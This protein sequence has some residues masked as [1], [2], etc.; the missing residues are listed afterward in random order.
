MKELWQSEERC[1]SSEPRNLEGKKKKNF[2][3]LLVKVLVVQWCP[4]LCDP[5][6]W[7]IACQDPLSMD[8]PRQEYWGG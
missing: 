2:Y 1:L 4:T 6:A 5:T 7:T 3:R 8:V